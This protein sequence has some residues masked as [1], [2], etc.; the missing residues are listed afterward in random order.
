V[1]ADHDV[2]RI[3]DQ[4]RRASDVGGH[5]LH[6]H[7]RHDREPE[8]PRQLHADR[9]DEQDR[10]QVV[11]KGREDARHEGEQDDQP[12]G[13]PA[14]EARN[15]QRQI[16]EDPSRLREPDDDHHPDQWP[17]RRPVDRLDRR[18]DVERANDDDD[19]GAYER[20]LRSMAELERHS[21]QGDREGGRR[22]NSHDGTSV[23]RSH[24]KRSEHAA[25]LSRRPHGNGV[26]TPSTSLAPP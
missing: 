16:G 1:R 24:Q 6:E 20:D 11:E 21:Q 2:G 5:H 14:G 7:E 25:C 23:L 22:N 13:T 19:R 26:A 4:G 15:L 12:E 8:Q 17:E 10:R 9:H 18:I 3:T